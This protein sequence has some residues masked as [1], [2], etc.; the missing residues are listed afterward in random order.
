LIKVVIVAVLGATFVSATVPVVA[1]SDCT[2]KV[3]VGAVKFTWYSS[4]MPASMLAE[5]RKL[6]VA[7]LAAVCT[8]PPFIEYDVTPAGSLKEPVTLV[9]CEGPLFDSDTVYV[10]VAPLGAFVGPLMVVARSYLAPTVRVPVA[11]LLPTFVSGLV[12]NDEPVTTS[13]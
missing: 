4:V 6:M 8:A 9:A 11:V 10:T 1:M 3:V 2:M 12:V 7:P 13:E 5:L